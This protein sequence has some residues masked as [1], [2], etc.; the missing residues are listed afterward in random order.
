[1]TLSVEQD[2]RR[3]EEN[4]TG[5]TF[6]VYSYLFLHSNRSVGPREVQRAL[7]FK[8]PSSAIFHL[9][10]LLNWNYVQKHPNGEYSLV[11]RQKIG[12]LNDFVDIRNR[13]IPRYA[14]YALI[15]SIITGALI[16]LFLRYGN[17][18]TILVTLPSLMAAIAL[19][20]ESYKVWKRLPRFLNSK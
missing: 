11:S 5:T 12:I 9:D 16:L 2:A 6:R 20:I 13:L 15:L 17:L 14:F 10:K 1:M 8:S 3:G 18:E 4:I 7:G 19:W